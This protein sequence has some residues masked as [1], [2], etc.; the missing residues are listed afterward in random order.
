MD[1]ALEIPNAGFCEVE[2]RVAAGE[3]ASTLAALFGKDCLGNSSAKPHLG[4]PS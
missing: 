4:P 2:E 3:D 1:S